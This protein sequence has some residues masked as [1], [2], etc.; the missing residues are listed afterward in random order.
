[1][2]KKV[3]APPFFW[4][5]TWV[6]YHKKGS[7]PLFPI[8]CPKRHLIHLRMVVIRITDWQ[9]ISTEQASHDVSNIISENNFLA[10]S[11]IYSK[12]WVN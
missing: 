11:G 3:A 1:M 12:K 10:M 5:G 8:F 7:I 9:G 4:L 2:I 6:L